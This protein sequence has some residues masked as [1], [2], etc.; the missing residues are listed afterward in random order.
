MGFIKK[1]IKSICNSS[2]FKPT[3]TMDIYS[4]FQNPIISRR[5][6]ITLEKKED[7]NIF[8]NKKVV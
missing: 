3:D 6:M 5:Q 4:V 8:N 2:S 7:K 1:I